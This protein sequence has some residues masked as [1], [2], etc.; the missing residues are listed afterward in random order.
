[1]KALKAKTFR[2]ATS[3]VASALVLSLVAGCAGSGNQGSGRGGANN[4]ATTTPSTSTTSGGAPGM[5]TPDVTGAAKVVSPSVV[6]VTVFQQGRGSQMT[7][8]NGSGIVIRQ[9]GYILTNNHVVE[10]AS[11]ETVTIGTE[12]LPAKVVGTDAATDLAVLKVNKTGL[13]AA[14]IGD[15][16]SLQVGQWVIEVGFPFGLD[17]TV[18]LGIVSG[19]GRT[20]IQPSQSDVTAYTNLIQ[21]DAAINPG[22]SGGALADLSG[23]VVGV[24]ALIESD[25]GQNSGIGFA[26]PI[27]FAMNIAQQLI[28]TGKAQ[29]AF[30]GI[31]VSTS[32]SNGQGQGAVIESVE[33]GSPAAVAGLRV[34][35]VITRIG[36]TD[37]TDATDVFA[38]VRA[39]QPGQRVAV[40]FARNGQT[41]TVTVTLTGRASKPSQPQSQ[42]GSGSGGMQLPPGHP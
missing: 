29:H 9:D 16:K 6:S 12:K 28:K 17:Q 7:A 22:N 2:V 8:G 39:R 42:D 32:G 15:P 26:I 34:N 35:D 25:S 38:A 3:L 24:N 1:M 11:G 23:R 40:R 4:N 19:L 36:N 31:G 37:I 18:T 27:D 14:E 13:D 5:T 30:M 33:K 41:Q 20:T 21:T 10:S